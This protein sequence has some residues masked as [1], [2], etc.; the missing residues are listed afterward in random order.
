MSKAGLRG[1]EA[2]DAVGHVMAKAAE[3]LANIKSGRRQRPDSMTKYFSRI[4]QTA[5]ADY[6]RA[7]PE[8]PS[9]LAPMEDSA[10]ADEAYGV[11]VDVGEG[12]EEYGGFR[13][14]R[15]KTLPPAPGA[16]KAPYLLRLIRI[17]SQ[18]PY[19]WDL[20]P[21]PPSAVRDAVLA[22]LRSAPC[23][24]PWRG[25]EEAQKRLAEL[26]ERTARAT[27]LY[28]QGMR[29]SEIARRLGI[30]RGAVTQLLSRACRQ[31]GWDRKGLELERL[32]LLFANLFAAVDTALTPFNSDSPRSGDDEGEFAIDWPTLSQEQQARRRNVEDMRRLT[33]GPERERGNGLG[34]AYR[35]AKERAVHKAITSHP[36]L[37]AWATGLEPDHMPEVIEFVEDLCQPDGEQ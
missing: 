24:E 31:W 5:L 29:M 9:R 12:D 37:K 6:F 19:T 22:A 36:W 26:P 4:C 10:I 16:T 8:K 15:P 7:A 20:K 27:R 28:L 14:F 23:D 32:R 13:A 33:S 35:Q 25:V 3:V 1:D 30:T 11:E 2:D 34:V 21:R 17:A 18:G